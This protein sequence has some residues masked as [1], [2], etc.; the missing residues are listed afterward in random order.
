LYNGAFQNVTGSDGI[1]D[2]P[3]V[4]DADNVDNY[5]L[6]SPYEYWTNPI[7]GDIN[8]DMEV[9]YRDLFQL[10]YAYGSSPAQPNWNPNA[11]INKDDKV[12]YKDLFILA[13]NFG[14]RSSQ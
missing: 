7:S 6:M 1:G 10:A 11:D 12:N 9:N 5:P 13:S 4:I 3:Y 14:R 2:T 8:R